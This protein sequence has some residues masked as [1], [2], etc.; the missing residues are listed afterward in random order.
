MSDFVGGG[1]VCQIIFGNSKQIR[2]Y[3][4]G[5]NTSGTNTGEVR[6]D[7]GYLEGENMLNII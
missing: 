6:L 5:G 7:T 2:E 4:G 1:G 3:L